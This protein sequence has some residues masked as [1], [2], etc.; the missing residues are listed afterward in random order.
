MKQI[1]FV[2]Q[3][4]KSFAE[5]LRKI[6]RWQRSNL[7][8]TVFFQIFTEV[9]DREIIGHIC[10]TVARTLPEALYAGCSAFGSILYGDFSGESIVIS[11][12]FFEY[13]TTKLEVLQYP[14]AAPSLAETA[15][16]VVREVDKR[17]WVKGVEMLA[18]IR[19]MSMTALCDGLGALREGV[20]VFGGGA[21]NNALEAEDTFVFSS[22]GGCSRNGI[23]FV[24]MGGEDL[25][26]ETSYITGW[27]PLGSY[28]DVT[29]ADGYILKE[30]NHRPAYE[31]YD[32]YLHI[33]NDGDFFVNT[34]E[35]PFFY[36]HN[37][38]DIMRAPISSN[39]D[40]S[41][42]MTS[43]MDQDVK[44]RIAYGDPWT[45]LDE[46][47]EEGNRL[48][49][50]TPDCI[51]VFSCAGRRTFWGDRE[52]GK[53]TESYQAAAPTSGF[54]TSG[55]F[56][57]TGKYLNLHNV[58][59]VLA[60]L[61]EG[62]V[63]EHEPRELALP[64]RDFRGR[65]SIINRMATFVKTATEE[66]EE[67]NRQLARMAV[68][69]GLT[70]LYNRT[71][72]QRRITEAVDEEKRDGLWLILLDLDYFKKINDRFG[73]KT[74][75][76]VL[77]KTSAVLQ[78]SAGVLP[79]GAVGRWGGEEFMMLLPSGTGAQVLELAEG[80]RKRISELKFEDPC[81]VTASLGA[82]RARQGERADKVC[83]RADEALYEAKSGG[84]N[85]VVFRES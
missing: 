50:F 26:L 30:L 76:E 8:S 62:A 83:V 78:D 9:P 81:A 68:T 65:V 11:C 54:Y 52:V 3:G 31:T 12:T 70:G 71:E 22:A 38:I 58:T 66:L 43:D 85:R 17:P 59:Q 27:K 60:A 55:E 46:T 33:P 28:L 57:R 56:L 10:D 77:R 49:K 20:Q 18:T 2:Y 41:L 19:G 24:L 4:E 67:L 23:V 21:L 25:F 69:D 53:E 74:G 39:A 80:I 16:Q 34:L 72:I 1:Q 51:F 7:C 79:G 36:H 14:L 63:R 15:A 61:R 37:G 42:V 45:I 32:K 48:M 5:E 47:I 13:P 82:V 40:G 29:A 84:R 73:H 35:F 75:D 44:A 64:A 6:C